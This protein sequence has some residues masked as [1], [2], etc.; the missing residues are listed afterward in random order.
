MTDAGT[1]LRAVLAQPEDEAVRLV[2]ADWLEEQGDPRAEFIRLQ[3][4]LAHSSPADALHFET[5]PEPARC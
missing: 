5:R 1:L 2:Y 4:A 3:I